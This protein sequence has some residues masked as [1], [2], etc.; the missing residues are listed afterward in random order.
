MINILCIIIYVYN[1]AGY[2]SNGGKEGE[3]RDNN[4]SKNE[5][6]ISLPS[7]WAANIDNDDKSD[8]SEEDPLLTVNVD[9]DFDIDAILSDK[10]NDVKKK[11]SNKKKEGKLKR[12]LKRKFKRA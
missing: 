1:G 2:F 3:L 10:P 7:T 12:I 11:K 5:D 4:D 9:E 8:S 6:L